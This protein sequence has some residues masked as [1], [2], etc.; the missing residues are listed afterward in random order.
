MIAQRSRVAWV[1][2]IGP[3]NPCATSEGMFPELSMCAW[4][5]TIASMPRGV[6]RKVPVSLLR[7]AAPAL[8]QAAL[9]K[10]PATRDL[11]HVHGPRNRAGAAEEED[12]DGRPGAVEGPDGRIGW[13]AGRR[14]DEA[15]RHRSGW[16]KARRRVVMTRR[17][18]VGRRIADG[19]RIPNDLP[20]ALTRPSVTGVAGTG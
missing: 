13:A 3:W 16:T 15:T 14:G 11:E 2:K 10:D 5:R 18:A 9:E 12:A 1:A 7:L 6:E 19:R 17:A 8:E 4:D 20:S